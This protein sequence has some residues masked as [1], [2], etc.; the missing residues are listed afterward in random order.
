MYLL[1]SDPNIIFNSAFWNGGGKILI[2][3]PLGIVGMGLGIS[4]VWML[5]T[6]I[7][8]ALGKTLLMLFPGHTVLQITMLVTMLTAITGS[9]RGG[10][11]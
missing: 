4:V 6:Y 2:G 11:R 1:I 5:S 9:F 10:H 7:H 8:R 3:L